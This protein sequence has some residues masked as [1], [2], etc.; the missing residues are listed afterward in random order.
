MFGKLIKHEFRASGR[1]MLPILLAMP[2]LGLLSNL[3]VRLLDV[4]SGVLSFF[5]GAILFIFGTACLGICFVSFVVMIVRWYR[6]VHSDEGYL[7]NTLPVSVHGIIW[8]RLLVA[9]VFFALSIL[10]LVLSGMLM[11][12]SRSFFTSMKDLI[13][14]ALHLDVEEW[15]QIMRICLS[16]LVMFL[17]YAVAKILHFYAAISI[18]HAFDNSKGFLS[19]VAF[20]ILQVIFVVASVKGVQLAMHLGLLDSLEKLGQF[21]LFGDLGFVL[22]GAVCYAITAWTARRKLNLK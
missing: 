17:I 15:S 16:V 1:I 3:A 22:Y 5:C 10:S 9:A 19:V 21:L 6:S 8:S 2:V 20:L 7:T 13:T 11:T 12:L 18:G 4:G 14:A